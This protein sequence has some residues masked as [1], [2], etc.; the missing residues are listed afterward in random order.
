MLIML[1]RK[2]VELVVYSYVFAAYTLALE[3]NT[4]LTI[5]ETTHC[6][7]PFTT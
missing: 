7:R 3:A 2:L 6:F 4:R 5:L 1:V